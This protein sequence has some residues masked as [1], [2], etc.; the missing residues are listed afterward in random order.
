MI[1]LSVVQTPYF[2]AKLPPYMHYAGV[3]AAIATEILRSITKQ[4]EDKLL[5]CVPPAVNIIT[6]TSRMDIL[7]Q[8]GGMQ[9]AYHSMLSLTGPLKGMLRLPG[10][11]MSPTQLFY[12]VYGQ[13]TCAMYDY[14][15]VR[16]T[17]DDFAE[18]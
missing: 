1:P 16:V 7:C 18:M 2:H 5:Q 6:N 12:L 8:S 17:S 15:G 3:G 10:I 13:T 4:F 11:N 14:A 9:I